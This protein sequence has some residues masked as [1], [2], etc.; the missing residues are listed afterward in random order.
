MSSLALLAND[1]LALSKEAGRRHSE[2]REV[3]IVLYPTKELPCY[4]CRATSSCANASLSD[5]TDGFSPCIDVYQAAER[6]HTLIK[7]NGEQALLDL[8]GGE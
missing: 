6:A 2:V 1:Y 8:R 4:I 7:T 5:D 3:S